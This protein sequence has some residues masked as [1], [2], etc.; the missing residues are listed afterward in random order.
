M[1][2]RVNLFERQLVTA[3]CI[4]RRFVVCTVHRTFQK[5]K[6]LWLCETQLCQLIVFDMV[7]YRYGRKNVHGVTVFRQQYW[8]CVC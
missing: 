3:G 4:M 2:L 7:I 8:S 1:N 5:S 6:R